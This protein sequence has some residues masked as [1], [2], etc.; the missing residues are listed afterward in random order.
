VCIV[1]FN[2][3]RLRGIQETEICSDNICDVSMNARGRV[4]YF[5]CVVGMEH[6]E[7]LNKHTD[8]II[9]WMEEG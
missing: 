9:Y 4:V 7:M 1:R 3:Q 8:W 5:I 6:T 2:K